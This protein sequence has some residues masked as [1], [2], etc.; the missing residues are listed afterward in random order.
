MRRGFKGLSKSAKPIAITLFLMIL[1]YCVSLLLMYGW[2][3]TTS[4]KSLAEYRKDL[5]GLPQGWPWEWEWENYVRVFEAISV[6][7]MLNGVRGEANFA[8]MFFNTFTYAALGA[9][10]TTFF[11]WCCAYLISK[12]PYLWGKFIFSFNLIMMFI[13]ITGNLASSLQIFKALGLYDNW[14]YVIFNSIG[15]GGMNLLIFH[16]FHEGLGNEYTEAARIDGAGNN[17]IM[18]KI[19][20]PLSRQIF[21]SVAMMAFIARWNDYMTMVVW[22]PNHPTMAYG[23]FYF[24]VTTTSE[25]SWPHKQIAA[26]MI[27]VVPILILYLFVQRTMLDNLRVGGLK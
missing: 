10:L 13:P 9:V 1:F 22:M 2:G 8:I 19:I 26:C 20:L 11:Q 16:A 4:L 24:S 15:F 5:Y 14:L 17:A 7:V 3:L 25:F 6:P 23:I 12:F 21:L 27:L 18:F